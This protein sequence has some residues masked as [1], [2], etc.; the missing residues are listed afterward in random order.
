MHLNKRN[1]SDSTFLPAVEPCEPRLLL[2]AAPIHGTPEVR[3]A[4]TSTS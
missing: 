3:F 2:S 4:A 1:K